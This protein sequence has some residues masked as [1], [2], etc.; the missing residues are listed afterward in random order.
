MNIGYVGDVRDVDHIHSRSVAAI[1]REEWVRGTDGQPTHVAKPKA[2]ADSKV[3]TESKERHVCRRP[4]GTVIR[5][6][7]P[8]PP[9][10]SA[11]V[12]H[13]APVVIGRPAPG[14]IRNP[15]P[16]VIRL[17]DPAAV[18]I[19]CPARLRRRNPHRSVVGDLTPG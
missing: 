19:R 16:A 14:L 10:P 1:P 11:A 13:P 9:T 8:G 5:I 15:R 12:N 7:R 17:P 3:V 2:G 18:A 6:N 4:D